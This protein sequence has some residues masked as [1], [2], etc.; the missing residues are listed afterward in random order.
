MPSLSEREKAVRLRLRDDLE[1]YAAK[2]LKIRTKDAKIEPLRFNSAQKH[3]HRIAEK[4][5]AET[6]KV[7]IITVKGRQQG[8][9]TYIQA[10]A[11]HKVT[12][13]RGV[14]GFTLTHEADASDRL[15]DMA[16]RFYQHCPELVRPAQGAHNAKE[17][18]FPLLDSSLEIGTAGNKAV[19]RSATIQFFA[20]SEVAFWPN[21]TEHARGILQTV[22]DVPGT[23]V[24]LESTGN[25]KGN[26]FAEQ[27][28]RAKAGETDFI[29]VFIPWFWQ[30]EYR[31]QSIGRMLD[32]D[33]K[34]LAQ[35]Y[36][37]DEGQLN[38]RRKKIAELGDEDAFRRE[39]PNT[40]DE[41]FKVAVRGS[42]YGD[43]VE[44]A[45]RAGRIGRVPYDPALV[46][47]TSWDLGLND[48]TAIW[49]WQRIGR[50]RRLIDYYEASGVGLDHYAKVLKEKPYVYGEHVLPHDVEVREIGNEAKTRRQVLNELGVQNIVV[51]PR[52]SPQERINASRLVLPLCWFDAKACERGLRALREYRREWVEKLQ[53]WS[54]GPLHDWASNGADA[55][56]M[57]AE[58]L[59]EVKQINWPE[60][61]NEGGGFYLK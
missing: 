12:H 21:A 55:F 4:Q 28:A 50:E 30:P 19:G 48:S 24:W 22:P 31:A 11:F 25:G 18:K 47:D 60:Y 16:E 61:A 7:R 42:Y 17:M 49:F 23:E 58:N 57:G 54:G 45:D 56:G 46:V 34:L 44:R 15:F 14:A 40:D 10:R 33:E 20:G 35:A 37:L 38:W 32:D 26:Y 51:A 13:W 36:G 5:R 39:Y 53:D 8:V 3:L 9:S 43:L 41:A 59:G 2:C 27:Y 1:H 29:A 6:G 52:T